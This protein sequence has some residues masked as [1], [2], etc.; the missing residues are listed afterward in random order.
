MPASNK[1]QLNYEE[2]FGV[3]DRFSRQADVINTMMQ[4]I[5]SKLDVLQN[6]GWIGRGA[7]AF[8]QEMQNDVLPGVRRLQGALAQASSE[9]QRMSDHAREIEEAAG[10]IFRRQA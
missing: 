2:I 4:N 3:R 5:S 6:G 1:I 9:L 8:F 10:A 7:E